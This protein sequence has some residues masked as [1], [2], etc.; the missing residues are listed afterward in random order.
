MPVPTGTGCKPRARALIELVDSPVTIYA[1][2]AV[3]VRRDSEIDDA[4]GR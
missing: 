1:T 2:A 3:A 4:I